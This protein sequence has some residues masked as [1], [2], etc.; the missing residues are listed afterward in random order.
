MRWFKIMCWFKIMLRLYDGARPILTLNL[1]H[2]P[3]AFEVL[4]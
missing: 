2:V 3:S 1:D 4:Q